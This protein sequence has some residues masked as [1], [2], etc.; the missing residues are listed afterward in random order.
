MNLV[1]ITGMS[2]AG[3]TI[4][5]RKFEDIGYYCID[6]VPPALL[7]QFAKLCLD[8][9][10]VQDAACVV[11]LRSGP[12]F[13]GLA[14]AIDALKALGVTPR[15]LFL[16]ASDEALVRR[17]KETRRKHPLFGR[18]KGVAESIRSER[19]AL[20]DVRADA[21]KVIDTSQLLARDLRKEIEDSFANG[22]LHGTTITLRSFGFKYGM[23]LDADLVLDVRHLVNPHYVAS[24]RDLDGR[25]PE[26]AD[27]IKADPATGAYLEKLLDLMEF[28]IPRYID[29]GKAY[30]TIGVGCTGGKHRS[31]MVAE[32]MARFLG[33]KGYKA[34]VQHR[35][36]KKAGG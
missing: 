10:S 4:V 6:N 34:V 24:L 21:D 27:Y 7:P 5:L 31:V 30:L 16:D 2:G 33:E 20:R 15:I 25:A 35:D 8:Q 29:E 22:N 28:S 36:V 23:P 26:V 11:D 18:R 17:F 13:A 3:R 32:E 1:L 14:A 12:F 19:A 9:G